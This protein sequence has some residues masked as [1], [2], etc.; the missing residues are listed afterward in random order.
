MNIL[1]F[2]TNAEFVATV[3][4]DTLVLVF[5][6]PAYRRTKMQAFGLLILGSTLGILTA[7]AQKL[8]HPSPYNTA[9]DLRTFWTIFLILCIASI[10][11]WGIAIY[12]LIQ[13]V[14]RDVEKND[15]PDA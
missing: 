4:I 6:Y 12:Q 2:L 1:S 11:S 15:K 7:S 8:F 3:L 14:I 10:V 9:N 13:Y 5:A